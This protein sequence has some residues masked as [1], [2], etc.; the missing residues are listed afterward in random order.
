MLI[1]VLIAVMLLLN[2]LAVPPAS[3]THVAEGATSPSHEGHGP[4]P[5]AAE[6]D[7]DESHAHHSSDVSNDMTGGDC[8]EAPG[9]D[10]GCA[11][12]HATTLPVSLP[13]L[14]WGVTLSEFTFAV[15]SFHSSPLSVPFRPPA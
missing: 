12:P 3:A 14:T 15:K 7:S 13:R 4:H 10:C 9:C 1:R 5:T 2:G 6:P 8:C 11:A